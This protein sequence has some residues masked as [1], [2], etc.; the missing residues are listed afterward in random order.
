M[1]KRAN[2]K[3]RDVTYSGVTVGSVWR[4]GDWWRCHVIRTGT[5]HGL[6]DSKRDAIKLVKQIHLEK[7]NDR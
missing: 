6:I 4:D 1:S 3:Y 5:S 7:E 2:T